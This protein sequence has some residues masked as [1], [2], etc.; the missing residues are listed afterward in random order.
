MELGMLVVTGARAPVRVP[1]RGTYEI[2]MQLWERRERRRSGVL[3]GDL[4]GGCRSNTFDCVAVLS[5]GDYGSQ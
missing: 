4:G 5:V 2:T 3:K 1:P